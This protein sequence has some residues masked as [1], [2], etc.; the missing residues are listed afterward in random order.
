MDD[1]Y[2]FPIATD[3]AR[4]TREALLIKIA[5]GLEIFF[6]EIRVSTVFKP[7]HLHNGHAF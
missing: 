3:R 6:Q 2:T 7:L 4:I 1:H 5:Q